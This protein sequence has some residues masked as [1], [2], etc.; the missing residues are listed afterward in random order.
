MQVN[1]KP[2]QLHIKQI[3]ENNVEQQRWTFT[4]SAGNSDQSQWCRL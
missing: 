2:E 1:V 4:G 3:S